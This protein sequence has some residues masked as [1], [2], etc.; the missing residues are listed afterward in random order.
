LFSSTV[1]TPSLPTS[2][3]P[4][5]LPADFVL[6]VRGNRADIADLLRT[7]DG[8]GLG[9]DVLDDKSDGLF[10]AALQVHRIHAGGDRLQAFLDD[11]LDEDRRGGRAISGRE[12]PSTLLP[13][14]AI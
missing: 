4:G 14:F 3:S 1:M 11:R 6:A 8:P 13:A 12:P 7:R 2:A 10:D 9:F 5:N